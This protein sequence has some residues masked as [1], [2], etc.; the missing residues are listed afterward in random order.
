M[1]AANEEAG[2]ARD[3]AIGFAIDQV[4]DDLGVTR[5]TLLDELGRT[6]DDLR[7]YIGTTEQRLGTQISDLGQQIGMRDFLSFLGQPGAVSQQV[8]V[9]MPEVADIGDLYSFESIF[10]TPEQEARF[11]TPYAEG[12]EVETGYSALESAHPRIQAEA[13]AL[14]EEFGLDPE[15]VAASMMMGDLEFQ[16]D[17]APFF[18]PF[19]QEEGIDPRRAR[20]IPSQRKYNTSGFYVYP[21]A[22]EENLKA[23]DKRY[24]QI[25]AQL[26]R[27]LGR[28]LTD[29]ER[30]FVEPDM[31]YAIGRGAT[32]RTWAHEFRHRRL[33]SGRGLGNERNVRYLDALYETDPI[34]QYLTEQFAEQ[35]GISNPLWAL[36]EIARNSFNPN[37]YDYLAEDLA[38]A[39]FIDPTEMYPRDMTFMEELVY[40]ADDPGMLA[41]QLLA[42]QNIQRGVG[43]LRKL[44][45]AQKRLEE[46]EDNK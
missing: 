20:L 17:V 40:D 45:E 22:T 43:A 37:A 23:L 28:E 24:S 21:E 13:L 29:S 36:K 39:G 19:G 3:E 42:P 5:E 18:G 44:R 34:S 26:E 38:E 14:A 46:E 16:A 11:A 41:K 6:E 15:M 10:R 8:D 4:A 12:G 30:V 27:D 7:D 9:E 33:G 31:I 35:A 32:P 25:P 2:I 1:V